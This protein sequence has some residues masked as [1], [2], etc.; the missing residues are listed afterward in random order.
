ME[1]AFGGEQVAQDLDAGATALVEAGQGAGRP[2]I[3]VQ[4]GAERAGGVR[5]FRVGAGAGHGLAAAGEGPVQEQGD[6]AP[7]GCGEAAA[8]GAVVGAGGCRQLAAAAFDG[9]LLVG[10]FDGGLPGM[11]LWMPESIREKRIK[12]QA[13]V[14]RPA[15]PPRSGYG[16][17][18]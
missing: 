2:E 5:A 16:R 18:P 6:I 4:A 17:S 13:A 14:T 9:G 7:V 12:G 11:R 10:L 15:A 1:P 8:A 3:A